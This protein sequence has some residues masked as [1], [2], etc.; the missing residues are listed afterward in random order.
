MVLAAV[1]QICSRNNVA[2]NLAVC[3]SVLAR[4]AAAGA[5]FVCLPE[6]ADYICPSDEGQSTLQ[7][8]PLANA[9]RS[10][11]IC[12][13][14]VVKLAQTLDDNSFVRGIQEQA[15]QSKVW[16][17]VGIHELPSSSSS[18]S[19]TQTNGQ[20]DKPRVYNTQCLISP[21][22]KLAS[23]YRKLHLFDVNFKGGMQTSE[24]NTTMK[25]SELSDITQTA[26][27]KGG[28][29]FSR[30]AVSHICTDVYGCAPAHQSGC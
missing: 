16:V 17:S 19:S 3:R 5:Q 8:R 20:Q 23:V 24:S 2:R 21:E 26:I 6:A 14:T 1:G 27:G 22:G 12:Y 15:K 28:C 9:D 25:G 29:P 13:D 7:A 10:M 18:S 11:H 30:L 4:A